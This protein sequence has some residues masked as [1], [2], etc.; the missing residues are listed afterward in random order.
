MTN[1]PSV[2]ISL[3]KLNNEPLIEF[4]LANCQPLLLANEFESDGMIKISTEGGY[5]YKWLWGSIDADLPVKVVKRNFLS[6]M[7]SKRNNTPIADRIFE[8]IKEEQPEFADRFKKKRGKELSLLLRRR[9]SKLF[10]DT[11]YREIVKRDIPAFTRH[12][13]ITTTQSKC[14]EVES[15]IKESMES[16]SIKGEVRLNTFDVRVI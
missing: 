4:D 7:F 3:L 8:I 1:L 16:F 2:F 6:M 12:D 9:E 11:I 10:I 13:G 5:F 15:I 14:D